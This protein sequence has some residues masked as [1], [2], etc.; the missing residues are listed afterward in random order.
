MRKNMRL[1]AILSAMILSAG[2]MSVPAFANTG[3]HTEDGST[4][5]AAIRHR[6]RTAPLR[7]VRRQE[8]RKNP[9]QQIL[10]RKSPGKH[11]RKAPST[12]R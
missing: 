8:R 11:R 7:T 9:Q 12:V 2:T 10:L 3:E 6:R 4:Q 5:A 1:I